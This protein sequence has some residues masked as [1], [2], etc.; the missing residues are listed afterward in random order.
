M[1]EKSY[2]QFT[3]SSMEHELQMALDFLHLSRIRADLHFLQ[4]LQQIA[5]G[6]GRRVFHL[7]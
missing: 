4:Q 5:I 2:R 3:Q 1:K 7:A 6:S